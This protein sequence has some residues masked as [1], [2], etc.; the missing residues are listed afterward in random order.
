M[1]CLFNIIRRQLYQTAATARNHNEVEQQSAQMP[2][3]LEHSAAKTNSI[4]YLDKTRQ[5]LFYSAQFY[6]TFR[7]KLQ[8]QLNTVQLRNKRK[9]K[10]VTVN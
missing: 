3:F 10:N 7:L 2:S 9:K 1:Y 4:V 8:R 6:R 5:D